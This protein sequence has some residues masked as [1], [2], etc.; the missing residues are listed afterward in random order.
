MSFRS[1][2][3][4]VT[5]PLSVMLVSGLFFGCAS[6]EDI[7]QLKKGQTEILAKLEKEVMPK[8]DKLEKT[9]AA[10]AAAAQ[11]GRPN[12][13]TVYA[14]PVGDSPAKG[15]VDAWVTIVEVSEFQCPFC[16]RVGPTLKQVQDTY[17]EDVRIVFKHNPLSFHQNAKPAAKAAECAREQGKFWELHDIM[18]ENQRDLS[19]PKLEEYAQQS[20][21]EIEAWKACFASTKHEDRI[22]QDQRVANQFGARGTPGF[23]INGRF[24]SGAQPFE[25]FKA[26][27]D[28]ELKK[29]KDSGVA[30]QDYYSKVVIEKGAKQM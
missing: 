7:E 18:F 12:P 2:A 29:A 21:V 17:G 24:L 8:L 3:A 20:G 13:S 30:K 9:A 22:N 6:P 16:K 11:P 1:I 27:I 10:P 28:E 23:F 19:G 15:P 25:S 26:V 14:V 4:Y 5:S